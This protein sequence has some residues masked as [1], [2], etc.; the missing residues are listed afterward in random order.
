ME[1]IFFT[2]MEKFLP[3]GVTITLSLVRIGEDITVSVLP[4]VNTLKD[5][6]ATQIVP[7]SMRGKSE[8]L[9]V[10]FS[11]NLEEPL[12]QAFKVLLNMAEFEKSLAQASSTCKAVKEQ[13]KK[14]DELVKKADDHEKKGDVKSAITY[15]IE[16][17]KF[18]SEQSRIQKRIDL[19]R[20]KMNTYSLFTDDAGEKTDEHQFNDNGEV[21]E[22]DEIKEFE[23]LI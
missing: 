21:Y 16:A 7:I 20:N 9:D 8:E 22:M 17:K 1:I 4:R 10:A 3:E 13:K 14:F 18:T 11:K 15:L 12:Q 19:L 2:E 5:Q 6:A 23:Q